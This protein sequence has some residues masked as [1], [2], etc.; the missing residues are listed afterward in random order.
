MQYPSFR[1]FL[2]FRPDQSSLH[3]LAVA[4]QTAGQ[5]R[6]LALLH[7]TVCVVAESLERDLFQAARLELALAGHALSSVPIRLGRV[8]GGANGAL[9][10]TIG[11]QDGIQDFY[12]VLLR[13]L[14]R[15]GIVPLYRESGLNPH[16]TLGYAP[17]R[18]DPFDIAVEWLPNELLLIESEVGK[19]RHNVVTRWPL[20]PPQQGVL[21]FT[22]PSPTIPISQAAVA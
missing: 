10:R 8:H 17:C 11:K 9:V 14:A 13:L 4:A 12:G 19:G 20:L 2:C 16:V 15:R 1:Y 21:N 22:P 6:P 7:L 18:F 3:A 5:R